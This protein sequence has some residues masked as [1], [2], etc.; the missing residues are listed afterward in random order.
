[1]ESLDDFLTKTFLLIKV[2]EAENEYNIN[3]N[4]NEEIGC[5]MKK[6]KKKIEN[7]K[8][9]C[10]EIIKI[11]EARDSEIDEYN[12]SN[13]E[14]DR[15]LKIKEMND[16]CQRMNKE[17]EKLEK[18]NSCT[19][20]EIESRKYELTQ[21]REEIDKEL[22]LLR[23]KEKKEQEIY[24]KSI[25]KC[26]EITC[27]EDNIKEIKE[28]KKQ[29][30]KS[31]QEDEKNIAVLE[32]HLKSV[33]L[34]LLKCQR[35][36]E[37]WITGTEEDKNKLNEL[38]DSEIKNL[39]KIESEIGLS[40]ELTY[41]QTLETEDSSEEIIEHLQL[42][43]QAVHEAIGDGIKH[44]ND[45][46][47]QIYY[48]QQRKLEKQLLYVEAKA[49]TDINIL[50]EKRQ[51]Q[52]AIIE[53]LLP[54]PTLYQTY[55][56]NQVKK[57][58]PMIYTDD[59][60][61]DNIDNSFNGN[62]KKE[63]DTI[64]GAIEENEEIVKNMENSLKD[65]IELRMASL[66]S[67]NDEDLLPLVEELSTSINMIEPKIAYPVL[68]QRI[69]FLKNI[70]SDGI[71]LLEDEKLVL[72]D[73]L[74]EITNEVNDQQKTVNNLKTNLKLKE[75]IIQKC[76]KDKINNEE[77]YKSIIEQVIND[78]YDEYNEQLRNIQIKEEE[79]ARLKESYEELMRKKNKKKV[80][81]MQKKVDNNNM[82]NK[83]KVARKKLEEEENRRREEEAIER[84]NIELENDILSLKK[85]IDDKGK[86]LKKLQE[87]N[88]ILKKEIKGIE[89]DREFGIY[90]QESQEK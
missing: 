17:L 38:L 69:K 59:K 72:K 42:E 7:L 2:L 78:N 10:N 4:D 68:W 85:E 23:K 83:L 88:D 62:R 30:E 41:F 15:S 54:Q 5:Y 18:D 31:I 67:E 16:E 60:N 28:K 40:E 90:F 50:K 84:M 61:E 34:V 82:N 58:V 29:V 51:Q 64:K 3:F 74:M 76:L 48:E 66:L 20:G 44:L 63:L 8:K 9:L 86:L 57:V 46:E 11:K 80:E 75:K 36:Y 87:A 35:A 27:L 43:L 81:V 26:H 37:A 55:K 39:K 19:C 65:N 45:I 24:N 79:V 33:L 89:L 73:K 1:M 52:I 53:R 13:D 47:K 14:I 70:L 71:S 25:E 56:N 32:N 22:E 12:K 77:K 21:L 6:I 49:R